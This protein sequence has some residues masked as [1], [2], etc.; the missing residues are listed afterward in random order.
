[1]VILQILLAGQPST[2]KSGKH[3][4]SNSHPFPSS[5]PLLQTLR[6]KEPH[7]NPA[8]SA[9]P[10]SPSCT[11]KRTRQNRRTS[12]KRQ[13]IVPCFASGLSASQRP[14]IRHKPRKTTPSASPRRYGKRSAAPKPACPSHFRCPNSPGRQSVFTSPLMAPP[15]SIPLWQLRQYTVQICPVEALGDIRCTPNI[16]SGQSD[17]APMPFS[18]S[19]DRAKSFPVLKRSGSSLVMPQAHMTKQSPKF[20]PAG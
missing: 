11:T 17:R 16:A 8:T 9:S 12:K 10:A 1:M 19:G 2:Q 4:S 3:P 13:R 6:R 14:P 5:D 18:M 7:I 15:G 20:N